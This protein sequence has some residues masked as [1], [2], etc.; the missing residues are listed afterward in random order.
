MNSKSIM[1]LYYPYDT[2]QITIE[3]TPEALKNKSKYM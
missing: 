2:T 1:P 3:T